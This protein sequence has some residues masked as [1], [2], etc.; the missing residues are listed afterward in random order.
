[1]SEKCPLDL[2]MLLL[3]L[4]IKLPFSASSVIASISIAAIDARSRL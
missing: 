2:A 4:A 3:Q 1:M